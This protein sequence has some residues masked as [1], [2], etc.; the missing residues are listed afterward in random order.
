M[1]KDFV[2][3]VGGKFQ[4]FD[5]LVGKVGS[6]GHAATSSCMGRVSNSVD[7]AF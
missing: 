2:I 1:L 6:D 5:R 7:D 4:V 3:V